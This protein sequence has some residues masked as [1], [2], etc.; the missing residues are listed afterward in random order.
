MIWETVDQALVNGGAVA[1]AP[2]TCTLT[3]RKGGH[4]RLWVSVSD[5]LMAELQWPAGASMLMQVGRGAM[6]GKVR[7]LP[8]FGGRA[9]RVLPGGKGYSVE[10]VVPEDL[11]RWQGPRA[12]AEHQV[13]KGGALLVTLPWALPMDDAGYYLPPSD[14]AEE[15][16]DTGTEDGAEAAAA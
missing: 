13:L 15:P 9:L 1:G 14:A 11:A 12:A 2:C 8:G 4:V 3:V 7:V 6:A 10:L 16:D 5:A